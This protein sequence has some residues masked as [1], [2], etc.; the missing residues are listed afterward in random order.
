MDSTPVINQI[1]V[2][3]SRRIDDSVSGADNGIK[4]SADG[5]IVSA[6]MRNHYCNMALRWV[7]NEMS[8]RFGP[9]E[10][11]I[12]SNGMMGTHGFTFSSA[13][14]TLRPDFMHVVHLT[15]TTVPGFKRYH[16]SELDADY[17]RIISRGFALEA[18]RIFG[19]QRTSGTLAILNSGTGHLDYIKADRI[20]N[21]ATA[22]GVAVLSADTVASVTIIDGGS[23]YQSVPAV[24]LIL[25]GGT[26]AAGT[27]VLSNG[28]VVSVTIT[29]AGSGYTSAPT[30]VFDAPTLPT[31][32]G[33][34]EAVGGEVLYN[35]VP[36]TT[37][38]QAWLEAVEHY[39]V[40]LVW[41]DKGMNNKDQ[42][43]LSRGMSYMELAQNKLPNVQK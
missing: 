38:E 36:D 1:S 28:K 25:G 30:V 5:T 14:V 21:G 42:E 37:L 18:G 8:K 4:A 16:K 12:M 22:N 20:V 39:A 40:G 41:Y 29:S 15:D 27:A 13:G 31:V 32:G 10:T 43:L 26:L 17:D 24:S 33:V 23:D 19:Y 35:T 34:L 11:S 6:F 9:L 3:V 7:A 2:N